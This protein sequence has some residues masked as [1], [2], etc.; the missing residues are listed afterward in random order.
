MGLN[1]ALGISLVVERSGHDFSRPSRTQPKAPVRVSHDRAE[2]S[3]KLR[4]RFLM[5]EPIQVEFLTTEPNLAERFGQGFSLASRRVSHDRA[6]PSRKLRSGLTFS[7]R[8][9]F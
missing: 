2:P 8:D 3:Q 1:Y 7:R 4:S 6:E 5:T 9:L